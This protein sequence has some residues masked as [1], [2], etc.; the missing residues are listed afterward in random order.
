MNFIPAILSMVSLERLGR[1]HWPDSMG[2]GAMDILGVVGVLLLLAVCL[3]VV[4]A[5]L[6]ALLAVHLFFCYCLKRTCEK[7]G[8]S[9]GLLVWFPIL[10]LFPQLAAAK[11]PGWMFLLYLVPLVNLGM[12]I[13]NWV[14]LCEA[15][16]KPGALGIIYLVPFGRLGLAIYLAFT[17]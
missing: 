6:T 9:P 11:L 4:C 15:R 8:H 2:N 12:A 10:N 3:A 16:G 13:F 1:L 5:L 7:A 17:D 14:K